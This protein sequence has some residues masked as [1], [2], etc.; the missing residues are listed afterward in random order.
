M[1]TADNS[2][3]ANYNSQDSAT[4]STGINAT[5]QDHQTFDAA[6]RDINFPAADSANVTA[7]LKADA[8]DEKALGTLSVNTDNAD[9]YNSVFDTVVPLQSSFEA[10]LTALD[11]DFGITSAASS[12]TP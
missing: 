12:P 10:A 4:A 2:N 8:A 9:Y 6:L 7:V 5:S 3:L 11:G 1:I